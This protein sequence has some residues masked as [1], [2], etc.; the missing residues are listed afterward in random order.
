MESKLN[1]DRTKDK[2]NSVLHRT[3]NSDSGEPRRALDS[4]LKGNR[5]KNFSPVKTS[6]TSSVYNQFCPQI[7]PH[8]SSVAGAEDRVGNLEQTPG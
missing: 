7:L 2:P 6:L 1:R 3:R 8:P 4:G 5:V